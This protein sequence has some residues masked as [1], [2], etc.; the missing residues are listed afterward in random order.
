MSDDL[1]QR[2]KAGRAPE[3][4]D[5]VELPPELVAAWLNGTATAEEAAFVEAAMAEAPE[6]LELFLQVPEGAPPQNMVATAQG[7]VSG[8]PRTASP[9]GWV[10]RAISVLRPAAFAFPAL[11]LAL[12]IGAS[13]GG[14]IVDHRLMVDNAV[15]AA[16]NPGFEAPPSL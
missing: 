6:S 9:S 15:T 4:P 8:K 3:A 11:A 1:W 12:W 16:L 7:L 5:A 13:M 14:A 2:A 10:D